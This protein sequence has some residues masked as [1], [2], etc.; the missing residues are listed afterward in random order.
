MV[1][2][3]PSIPMEAGATT[4]SNSTAYTLA[5]RQKAFVAHANVSGT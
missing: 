2:A 1:A 5:D 4:S 3:L